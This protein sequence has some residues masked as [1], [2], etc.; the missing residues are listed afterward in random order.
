MS[1]PTH[2]TVDQQQQQ[3]VITPEV[4]FRKRPAE[5]DSV[6]KHIKK[7]RPIDRFAPP[8][9]EAYIPESQLYTELCE[10]ERKLD[11]AIMQKRLSIQEALGKPNKRTLRI[12]VSNT[13]ADQSNLQADEANP[14][15]SNEDNSPSW[16]LRVEGRLLDPLIPTK[17]AQPVQKFSSFFKSIIIQLDRDPEQYPEGNLTEWHK[18]PSMVDVDGVEL[19]RK[20]D[21]D[22]NAK[23]ILV[24]DFTP[25]KYKTSKALANIIKLHLATKA[26]ILAELNHYIRLNHLQDE[27]DK[28]KINCNDA[29]KGLL[30]GL[31]VVE[32]KD[33][34][35]LL[36]IE[37]CHIAMPDPIVIDY[38]IQVE[39]G[40]QFHPPVFAYDMEVELDSLLRQ[41]MLNTVA[42]SSPSQKEI[43][44]LDDKI[45]Q[46]TQSINNSKQK[47]DFLQQ[48]ATSPVQFIHK[49]ITS[50][51]YELEISLGQTHVNLE[52]VRQSEFYKQPWVK[53]AVFH[54]LTSK[55][56]QRMQ[57]LLATQQQQK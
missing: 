47:C 24:P 50:Q 3:S 38:T 32:F 39:D 9:I 15:E 35:H 56:Q 48:F 23:I 22:V 28:R 27:T 36:F 49:W 54:Y 29:L 44:S 30:D 46:C 34:P 40:R 37:H 13:A 11:R 57:E 52:E 55:T 33:L 53:E 19:K 25:Q 43:L 26:Q 20:G 42:S 2:P 1:Q 7:K 41:K 16:I 21:K 51:A 17:K 6:S 10:L 18:Q 4:H 8:R 45:V 12:F 5:A 14:F 31:E